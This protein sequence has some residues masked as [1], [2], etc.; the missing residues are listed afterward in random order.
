MF[1]Q[2]PGLCFGTKS[3]Q[4]LIKDFPEG[5]L[6]PKRGANLSFGQI[7]LKTMEMK[8]IVARPKLARPK[9]ARPKLSM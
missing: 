6:T 1:I 9:L 2:K 7:F 4:G 8:I 3:F 5:V